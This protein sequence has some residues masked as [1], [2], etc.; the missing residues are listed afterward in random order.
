M[1]NPGAG[2]HLHYGR[3][4]HLNDDNKGY[5]S[6]VSS[7]TGGDDNTTNP[8]E[9][10][11]LQSLEAKGGDAARGKR[12]TLSADHYQ[13]VQQANKSKARIHANELELKAEKQVKYELQAR[14]KELENELAVRKE[15]T[16]KLKLETWILTDARNIIVSGLKDG[17]SPRD[18]QLKLDWY[19]TN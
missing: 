1:S 16:Q 7:L 15:K 17:E 3:S 12:K 11:I 19:E 13:L 10:Y 6:S 9:R 4:I 8:N 14:I 5:D 2:K 18:I